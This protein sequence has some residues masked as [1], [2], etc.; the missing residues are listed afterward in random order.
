LN[1]K[2]LLYWVEKALC[3]ICIIIFLGA[4]LQ[5]EP[6]KLFGC[7]FIPPHLRIDPTIGLMLGALGPFA[8]IMVSHFMKYV[9][10]D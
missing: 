10:S 3:S 8:I 2:K 4:L 5:P 7:E 9:V 6:F 1:L